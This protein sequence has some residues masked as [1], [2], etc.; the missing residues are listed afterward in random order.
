[1]HIST[2][3][4]EY[5]IGSFGAN[6]KRFIDFLSDCGFKYWQTLPFNMS[7]EVGS[8]Y[9]SYGAFSG[10]PFFVDLDILFEK[11]LI[12]NF[13]KIKLYNGGSYGICSSN[14]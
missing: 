12:Q 9:K 11:G 8:P 10:N 1:M 6:A 5:S 3:Y 14:A 13:L 2:L 4:G 7:D